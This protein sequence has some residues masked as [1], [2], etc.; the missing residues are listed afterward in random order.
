VLRQVFWATASNF[1][2]EFGHIKEDLQR[3]TRLMESHG[4]LIQIEEIQHL[5]KVAE[6]EF[7]EQ[8]K[9]ER[10][11]QRAA[12]RDWLQSASAD[13]DQEAR[14]EARKEYPGVCSWI[15]SQERFTKWKDFKS[16]IGSLL[17]VTGKPGAG[18]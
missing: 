5:T 4:N 13:E 12:V 16:Q 10:L 7:N 8:K 17:W 15:Q 3:Q 2:T 11:R 1:R 9:S 14:S 6:A 18:M